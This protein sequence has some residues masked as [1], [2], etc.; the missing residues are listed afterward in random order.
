MKMFG[1][2]FRRLAPSERMDRWCRWTTLMNEKG[3][4]ELCGRPAVIQFE[5]TRCARRGEVKTERL[6]YC[7]THGEH[8]ARLYGARIGAIDDA[9]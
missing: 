6:D 1:F 9:A 4:P 2:H 7:Q 5:G 3:A 8:V